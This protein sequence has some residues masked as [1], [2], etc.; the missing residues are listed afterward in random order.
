MLVNS[1][2]SFFKTN[3]TQN[4]KPSFGALKPE[5]VRNQ[6]KILLTQ[7]IWNPKLKVKIP[8]SDMEKEVLL[9]VLNN[10]KKLDTYSWYKMKISSAVSELEYVK[11]LL[12]KPLE[13]QDLSRRLKEIH[14][15]LPDWGPISNFEKKMKHTAARNEKALN[16]FDE[17]DTLKDTYIQSK[18]I[19]ESQLKR[20]WNKVV[21]GNINSKGS[22]ST[23]DMIDIIKDTPVAK[24]GTLNEVPSLSR[25]ELLNLCENQ[26]V[27]YIR[28]NLNIYKEHC[29][30]LWDVKNDA[31]KA[32]IKKFGNILSVFPN[33]Y[34]QLYKACK[35]MEDMFYKL[36]DKTSV[37]IPWDVRIDMDDI[38]F[39]MQNIEKLLSKDLKTIERLKKTIANNPDNE[40]IE[41]ALKIFK[42]INSLKED[43]LKNMQY[44]VEYDTE[45]R[46]K[47]MRTDSFETF[48]YLTSENKTL[49]KLKTAKEFV[50]NHKKIPDSFWTD[51]VLKD[52]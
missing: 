48:E 34:T 30:Q 3:Y 13:G 37:N 50:E 33:I 22:L 11:E 36:I 40:T 19:K 52:G 2:S 44:F 45:C 32:V 25:E 20:F 26:Y 46:T 35:P 51:I 14:S 29:K 39:D 31:T 41:R 47:A 6:F 10:R 8:E 23:K 12:S 42:Q 38:F 49:K 21:E 18:L 24:K 15:C 27:Q 28:E 5:I 17:I 4:N 9:E 16:Y 1:I 7:D 43:W